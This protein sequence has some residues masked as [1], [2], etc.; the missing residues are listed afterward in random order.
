MLDAKGNLPED[1]DEVAAMLRERKILFAPASGRQYYA[2]LRQFE[3]YGD[4]FIFLSEN[5][6]HVV[7]QGKALFSSPLDRTIVDEMLVIAGTVPDA[8]VVL[9][10]KRSAY[11]VSEDAAFM[12]EVELYY[13]RYEI[14]RDFSEVEDEIL[15]IAIC[16]LSESGAEFNSYPHFSAYTDLLQ[17]PI[18]GKLWMDVMDRAANKGV[19]VTKI[20]RM[21]GISPEECVAFGDYLN[22]R[23]MMQSV[24]YSYAMENAHPRIKEIAR[25]R[26]KRN[27]ENGVMDIIRKILR[28]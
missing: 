7:Y 14:V 25:F 26:A 1:F 22:D 10:G 11:I 2:L 17:I 6:T 19:A 13:A 20:Q 8:H 21:F 4:E 27:T 9:C 15:K 28:G 16:D 18:S 24:V 12:R 23:E 5:G 3:R